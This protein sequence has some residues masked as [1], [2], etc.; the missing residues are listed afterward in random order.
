MRLAT[1][2]FSTHRGSRPLASAFGPPASSAVGPRPAETWP[3]GLQLAHVA[4][5]D[6]SRVGF[7]QMRADER[8][9][10]T[11]DFLLAVVARSATRGVRIQRLLAYKGLCMPF[12]LF[13]MSCKALGIKPNEPKRGFSRHM[14]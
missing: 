6:H 7:P 5:D 2:R 10:S 12:A 3:H 4:I 9:G 11:V 1:P 13:A 8:T 14:P